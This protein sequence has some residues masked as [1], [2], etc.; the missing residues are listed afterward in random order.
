MESVM[1]NIFSIASLLLTG[2][3]L[4]T[5]ASAADPVYK[6]KDSAGHSHYSQTPPE[7]QKYEIITQT[8]HVPG[9][10]VTA[11]D[12]PAENTE[13]PKATGP[14]PAQVAR[15]KL[16]EDARA[17]VNTLNTHATVISDVNGD[18]KPVTLNVAQHA[19]SLAQ[20]N[21]QV[22]LYCVQ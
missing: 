19:A 8:S 16:C 13:T 7:G 10:N 11:T 5:T 3:I 12:T 2:L 14:T 9:K 18:G 20:A 15:K 1:R 6:W 22:D 21:K 4:S 17:N